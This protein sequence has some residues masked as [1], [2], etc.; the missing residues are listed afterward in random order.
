M[1]PISLSTGADAIS[2][3]HH[4]IL[5]YMSL[6]NLRIGARLYLAF[7]LVLLMLLAISV[8]GVTRIRLLEQRMEEI[9]LVNDAKIALTSKMRVSMDDRMIALRN[10]VL[11]QTTEEI[12]PEFDRFTAQNK[13]F[14]SAVADLENI[15]DSHV[16]TGDDER[17]AL[18]RIKAA[19]REAAPILQKVATLGRLNEDAEATQI[20]L[21]D[22]RPVQRKWKSVVAALADLETRH[23]DDAVKTSKVAYCQALLAIALITATA[24][25]L[26][27]IVA[28]TITRSIVGPLKEAVQVAEK[29]ARGDLTNQIVVSGKDET[30]ELMGALDKMTGSLAALVISVRSSATAVSRSSDE[31][32][33][34]NCDLSTRTEEQASSLEET[35]AAMEELTSTV[36][37]NADNAGQANSLATHA[38]QVVERGGTIVAQ[39]VETMNA[40]CLSSRKITEIIGVIDGIAFQTNILALN[41]AVEAARAGEHGRGFAVV[42]TEVRNLAHRSATAAREIKVLITTSVATVDSGNELATEAGATMRKALDSVRKVTEIMADISH[43]TQ[44]QSAG[45]AQVNV[46]VANMDAMTQQN[47]ALVE[48]AAAAATESSRQAEALTSEL[49]RF[50][51]EA[52]RRPL[53]LA[54]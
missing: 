36:R 27:G 34:G 35:A 28:W 24:I 48:Q 40:I 3:R 37:Q 53:S 31:I 4:H 43:A 51:T 20:L 11:L 38:A 1:P 8:L 7:A 26:G 39:M 25:V 52:N 29:V 9:M 6:K 18:M 17:E 45:I 2:R 21:G 19:A 32:A 23:S 54:V 41:A 49:A 12:Q 42:A 16:G 33:S 13:A 44:E 47:A 15:F 30:A 22:L 5:K 50:R 10:I 46:A 14:D